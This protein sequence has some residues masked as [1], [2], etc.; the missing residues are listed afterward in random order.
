MKGDLRSLEVM[1]ATSVEEV[2][3][4]VACGIDGVIVTLLEDSYQPV[5]ELPDRSPATSFMAEQERLA[6]AARAG[7]LKIAWQTKSPYRPG[8]DLNH[9]ED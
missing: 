6:A 7:V 9:R 1:P 8:R 4:S 2:A 5:L 3:G